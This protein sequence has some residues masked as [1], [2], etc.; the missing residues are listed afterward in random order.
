MENSST[1]EKLLKPYN[2]SDEESRMYTKWEDSGFFTPEC[3]I[4]AGLTAPDAKPFTI[5]LPPPNVTG[6]LHMGHAMMLT[7][8]D[9]LI[10][11]KRMQGYRTL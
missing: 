3:M 5:V 6:V 7:I 4:D 11:Y 9:I 8:Q 10:R 1:P 2:P